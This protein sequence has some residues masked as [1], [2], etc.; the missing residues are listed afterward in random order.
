MRRI[1][2][3]KTG[4]TTESLARR[5]GDFEDWILQ[6][7]DAEITAAYID[8]FRAVLEKEGQDADALLA[9]CVHPSPAAAVLKR[10]GELVRLGC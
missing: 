3:I 7:F 2:I 1:A 5:R 9:G 10:F 6:G 8:T 4:S